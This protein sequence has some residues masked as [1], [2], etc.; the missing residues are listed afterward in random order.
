MTGDPVKSVPLP[1]GPASLCFE[2]DD[3]MKVRLGEQMQKSA[4][5]Y[6][7]LVGGVWEFIQLEISVP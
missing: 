5:L 6:Y 3:F 1:S 4:F 2:K 7:V